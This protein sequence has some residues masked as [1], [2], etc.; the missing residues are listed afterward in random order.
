M[1]RYLLKMLMAALIALSIDS[2]A[3]NQ[4]LLTPVTGPEL[5]E[6]RSNNE[7]FLKKHLYRAKQH[8][9]VRVD[10]DVLLS[11]EPFVISL[12]GSDELAVVPSE[13]EILGEDSTTIR[14]TGSFENPYLSV[15]E[16]LSN[17][18]SIKQAAA[19]HDAMFGVQIYGAKYEHDTESGANFPVLARGNLPEEYYERHRTRSG[20]PTFYSVSA[21]F[22]NNERTKRYQLKPL[23]MGGS[24]HILIETDPSKMVPAGL[25]VDPK[26][27][28]MAEKRREAIEFFDSLGEDP[29]IAII[30]GK[31][32]Q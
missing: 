22:Y 30:R 25:L 6:V 26:N 19:M 3:Q 7:Y 24:N 9:I 12:F 20:N 29:R 31:R 13:V 5:A 1:P 21:N 32:P 8:R 18:D 4:E 14:W 10:M 2:I 11:E 23:E 16:L 15:D 28:E 17:A 27:P